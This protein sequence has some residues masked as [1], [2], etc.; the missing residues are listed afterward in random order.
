MGALQKNIF[1]AL[2]A[3]LPEIYPDKDKIELHY[4]EVDVQ[5]PAPLL[6]GITITTKETKITVFIPYS[7]DCN[8]LRLKTNTFTTSGKPR[9]TVRGGNIIFSIFLGNMNSEEMDK[10]IDEKVEHIKIYLGFLETDI[11]SYNAQI[12]T[13]L[14]ELLP[15]RKQKLEADKNLM[16]GSKYKRKVG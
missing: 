7:G 4:A 3:T 9:G 15:L 14:K 10:A 13:L 8:L 1:N 6:G 12:I 5:K 2:S 16:K 11:E